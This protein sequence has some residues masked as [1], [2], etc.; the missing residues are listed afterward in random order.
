MNFFFANNIAR[1]VTS[2]SA[3]SHLGLYCL[4]M[5]LYCLPMGLYC[6]PMGLYCL[7]MGL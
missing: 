1:D 7:P 4:P 2:H 6:L 5:G 3:A